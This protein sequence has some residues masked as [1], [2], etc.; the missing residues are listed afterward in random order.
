MS[1]LACSNCKRELRGH[2]DETTWFEAEQCVFCTSCASQV[3]DTRGPFERVTRLKQY[4]YLLR[5]ALARLLLRL[6][7]GG[8]L[9]H[10][11]GTNYMLVGFKKNI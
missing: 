7:Q 5:V 11:S 4:V 2:L 6:R 8:T 9:P 10:T 3:S 1:C